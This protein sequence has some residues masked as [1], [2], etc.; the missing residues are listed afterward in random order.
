MKPDLV[1]EHWFTQPKLII[2]RTGEQFKTCVDRSNYYLSNNLF[3]SFYVDKLAVNPDY[4]YLCSLFNSNLLQKFLRIRIAPC[5]G[6]LYVE[7]KIKHLDLLPIKQITF[8]TPTDERERL[9]QQAMGAYDLHDN[10][11]V[12]QR[13]RAAIAADQTDVVHDV[14]AQAAQRMIDLNKQKQAEIKRFLGLG[15]GQFGDWPSP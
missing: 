10:A 4:E 1:S 14:L 12:L 3:S 6:T 11:G 9:T 15:G 7:T 2:V 8:T 5:F 13:M